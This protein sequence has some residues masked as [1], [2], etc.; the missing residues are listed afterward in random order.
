MTKNIKELYYILWGKVVFNNELH[1]IDSF[2]KI[3]TPTCQI[4]LRL[5]GYK[6][7]VSEKDIVLALKKK[8]EI[9]DLLEPKNII[10]YI[11]NGYDIFGLI[12]K[13]IAIPYESTN[14]RTKKANARKRH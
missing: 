3:N 4:I 14:D 2:Y 6:F 7:M 1:N 12:D 10:Q 9:N 11:K 8:N 13:K 5:D